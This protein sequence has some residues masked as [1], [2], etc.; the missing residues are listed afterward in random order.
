MVINVKEIVKAKLGEMD[1]ALGD[2]LVSVV[3]MI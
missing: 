1:Q 2:I 3:K